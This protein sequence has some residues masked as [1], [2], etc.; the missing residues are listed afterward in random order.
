MKPDPKILRQQIM[1][2]P[3]APPA[4]LNERQ[5]DYYRLG[6]RHAR[7]AAAEHVAAEFQRHGENGEIRALKQ[8]LASYKAVLR[9]DSKPRKEGPTREK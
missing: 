8:E 3:C 7:H 4:A 2:L 9:S 1:D 5:A 6:H